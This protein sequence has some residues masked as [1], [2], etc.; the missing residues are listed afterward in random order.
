[1]NKPR[2]YEVSVLDASAFRGR[3]VSSE[4]VM[5]YDARDAVYQVSLSLRGTP[6]R[7]VAVRPSVAEAAGFSDVP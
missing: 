4:T 2:A 6:K 5:A 1:M 3:E 7:A